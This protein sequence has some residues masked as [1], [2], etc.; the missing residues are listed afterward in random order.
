MK[1]P[2]TKQETK[3]DAQGT[4]NTVL[5]VGRGQRGGAGWLDLGRDYLILC[6]LFCF[7]FSPSHPLHQ[8]VLLHPDMPID[9]TDGQHFRRKFLERRTV[10]M[11]GTLLQRLAWLVHDSCDFWGSF[12][13]AEA[14]VAYILRTVQNAVVRNAH[15]KEAKSQASLWVTKITHRF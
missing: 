5:H 4:A 14:G 10:V 15:G 7:P 2:Q 13:K 6:L 11:A 8:V 9:H 12:N 1:F 3:N